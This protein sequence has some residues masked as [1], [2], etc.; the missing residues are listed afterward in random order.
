MFT[1]ER[2][3][4]TRSLVF[5]V[6]GFGRSGTYTQ[7]CTE[8]REGWEGLFGKESLGGVPAPVPVSPW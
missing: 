1:R 7:A 5:E 4:V 2:G 3:P 6:G 8:L